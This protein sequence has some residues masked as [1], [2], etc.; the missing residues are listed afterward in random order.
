MGM[1]KW[2]PAVMI[3]LSFRAFTG[4]E[5]MRAARNLPVRGRPSHVRRKIASTKDDS[6]PCVVADKQ[7]EYTATASSV[8]EQ[9]VAAQAAGNGDRFASPSTYFR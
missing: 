5:G 9:L 7:H 4:L 6:S 3:G 1:R 2:I 8:E